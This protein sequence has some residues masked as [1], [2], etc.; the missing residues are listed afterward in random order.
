MRVTQSMLSNNSLRHIQN[1]FRSMGKLEEQLTTGKKVNR[2]SDDPVV[3]MK[4]MRYRS[5]V[6]EVEQFQR[7][8]SEVYNWMDN[9]DAAL[10]E[11]N[12]VMQR[13]RELTVQASNDSYEEKQRQSIASELKQLRVHLESIA[14]TKVNNKYIFNGSDTS[15][16][17]VDLAKVDETV[18]LGTIEAGNAGKYSLFTES[19]EQ[20]L[21]NEFKGTYVGKDGSEVNVPVTGDYIAKEI[22]AVAVNS[23]NVD[24]EVSKGVQLNVNIKPQ[25]VFSLNFFSD[26]KDLIDKMESPESSG[27][28]LNKFL[29]TLD[30]HIDKIIS[31]R[32]ELGA[33]YNRV[34][35][36]ESRLMSQEI[37]AKQ[38]MSENEDID[39]EKVI[40][41]LTSQETLHRAALAVGAKIIQPSL[42]D[43]LR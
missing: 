5:Q 1:S 12:S 30:S 37:I 3:A 14:N 13:V 2:P 21:W 29:G 22:G 25:N 9:A 34:E 33:R 7:N 10:N 32:A 20:L 26:L 38:T 23:N 35:M 27:E 39:A 28:D 18:D 24:I 40:I 43:F 6:V 4:G 36:V 17:P 31:E 11:V 8:L 16:K 19:G 42:I 15:G 41:D